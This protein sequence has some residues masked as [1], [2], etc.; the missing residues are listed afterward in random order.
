M[1]CP[2]LIINKRKSIMLGNTITLAK[3]TPDFDSASENNKY[4]KK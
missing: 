4:S 1:K 2:D 3:S